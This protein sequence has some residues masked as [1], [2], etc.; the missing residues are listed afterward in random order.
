MASH[1]DAQLQGYPPAHGRN[2]YST[3]RDERGHKMRSVWRR[4]GDVD[5]V[6]GAPIHEQYIIRIIS[7]PAKNGW[8][9]DDAGRDRVDAL[10]GKNLGDDQEIAAIARR[11]ATNSE[12]V[13][14]EWVGSQIYDAARLLEWY[15]ANRDKTAAFFPSAPGLTGRKWFFKNEERPPRALPAPQF[16]LQP[17]VARPTKR[18]VVSLAAFPG[19][20]FLSAS[21]AELRLWSEKD[22]V[23]TS[24]ATALT[25]KLMNFAV[26]QEGSVALNFSDLGRIDVWRWTDKGWRT[27]IVMDNDVDASV[28]SPVYQDGKIKADTLAIGTIDKTKARY[29]PSV[30][31]LRWEG[32]IVHEEA[33]LNHEGD[34][35]AE[36]VSALVAFPD[37]RIASAAT[38]IHVWRK[39]TIG[40]KWRVAI[41]GRDLGKVDALAVL[42]HGRLA[43]AYDDGIVRVWRQDKGE[44]KLE[45]TIDEHEYAVSSLAVLPDG[46]LVTG[47]YDKTARVWEERYDA[48]SDKQLWREW[49]IVR[50]NPVA[51]GNE[52]ITA[53][54]ALPDG[55]F[56]TGAADGIVNVHRIPASGPTQVGVEAIGCAACGNAA[57][58]AEPD[59]QRAFCDAACQRAFR[60]GQ[61]TVSI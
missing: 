34:K 32:A 5:R 50:Q 4:D 48:A 24:Q 10:T 3:A 51:G 37:G 11:T 43:A 23:W 38:S 19:A 41:F 33:N 61:M 28:I 60:E 40:N 8:R 1:I 22:G 16:S 21:D 27:R 58:F 56:V 17:V 54:A 29:P 9:F 47:S 49:L 12:D 59:S 13:V 26:L 30:R 39:N 35:D 2:A 44:W 18:A 7:N 46:R 6:N 36:F 15:R 25:T 45:T 31:I 53:L 52:G 55:R 20:R 42:P 57:S 14:T